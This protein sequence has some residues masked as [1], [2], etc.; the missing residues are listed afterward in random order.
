MPEEISIDPLNHIIVVRSSGHITV[1]DLTSS[2]E[3]IFE[4]YSETGIN[5]VL[6]DA[7]EQKS[8]IT[9]TDSYRRTDDFGEN[10]ISRKLKFAVL[11]SIH[12]EKEL[13]FLETASRNKGLHV[14]I[15]DSK[16]SAIKWLKGEL[17][18]NK[19]L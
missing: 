6:V 3:K 15:H 2:R 9:I 12:T 7:R 13:R 5:K 1:N 4:I 10:P 14:M 11:P 8:F 16:E 18:S 17:Q 19:A